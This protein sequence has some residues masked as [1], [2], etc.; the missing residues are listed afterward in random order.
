MRQR[1]LIKTEYRETS[2]YWIELI[3]G[4]ENGLDPG[5]HGI[6]EDTKGEAYRTLK[7]ARPCDCAD[8]K[9]RLEARGQ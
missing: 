4:W 7:Y 6:V 5:T 2:G 1:G 8:C 3:D 9:A